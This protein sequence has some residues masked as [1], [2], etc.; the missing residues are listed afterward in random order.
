MAYDS[1][2]STTIAAGQ[3]ALLGGNVEVDGTTSNVTITTGRDITG[4]GTV[5]AGQDT[6]LTAGRNL[7]MTGTIKTGNNLGLQAGQDLTVGPTLAAG[8]TETVTATNGSAT[9]GGAALS[10][11]D[12]RVTAGTDVTTQG[13][14]E[15]LGNL[16]LTAQSGSL[17]ANGPVQAAGNATLNAGQT[18]GLNGATTVSRNLT[19]TGNN[20]TTQGVA[21]GGNLSATAQNNLDTS[22]AQVNSTALDPTAPIT[23]NTPAFTSVNGTATLK[24]AHVTT[25]NAVIGG[26]YNATGTSSLTTG[27]KAIYLAGAN[28]N[29]GTVTNVGQQLA[30]GNLNVSGT[31]VSNQGVLSSQAASTIT[32]TDLTNSGLVQGLTNTLNVAN[33]TT[34]TGALVGVNALNLNTTSLNNS[35]GIIFA[36]NLAA[37]SAVTGDATVTVTGGNGSF[38]N[39]NGEIL[40]AKKRLRWPQTWSKTEKF[41]ATQRSAAGQSADSG[42]LLREPVLFLTAARSRSAGTW[43]AG[44][45]TPPMRSRRTPR[46]KRCPDPQLKPCQQRP[47]RPDR[48]QGQ[49]HRQRRQAAL[50]Q[51]GRDESQGEHREQNFPASHAA[52]RRVM[53]SWTAMLST[54]KS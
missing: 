45:A 12:M 43:V 51:Q 26:A 10:A 36:G 38:I 34:N 52:H 47:N 17:S 6:T 46:R 35:N 4:S 21:V 28:L 54:A 42:V 5:Q 29:G 3:D 37:P 30:N 14:V 25:V 24:G 2:Q 44:F 40:G 41:S 23:A 48:S 27:G 50:G 49:G 39:T 9:L 33:S 22:A 15:S 20:I 31:T 32:A 8:G 11:G 16:T 53:A 13:S 1:G 7:S 19:L 18:L